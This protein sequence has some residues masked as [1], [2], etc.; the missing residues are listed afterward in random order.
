MFGHA[1]YD[2][3]EQVHFAHDEASGLTAIVAI[4]STALGP[5]FGGCRMWPYE[6]EDRALADA[7]RLLRGMTYKAAI[8]ELPYGGGKSVII[9]DPK[10]QKTDR[11]LH[12]MG[13]VVDGFG[14]AYIIADDVGIGLADLAVMRHE[15]P[16]TAAASAAAQAPL[17][18]TGYGVLMAIEAATS[19]VL[20]RADLAGLRVAV[21]G[22]GAVGLALCRLLHERGARLIVADIDDARV[23]DA[24]ASFAAEAVPAD[25]IYDVEADIFAPCALGAVLNEETVQR[26][27]VALVC[28]GA[29]NQLRYPHHDIELA[30]RG[31]VFVPDY[32]ANAGGVIDYYQEN[33]DDRPEAILR[34]VERIRD[35]TADLLARAK[36]S[37]DTPRTVAEKI[38]A[39]RLAAAV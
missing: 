6:D 2:G 8:C 20:G 14:G 32:L 33:I 38:V 13:R 7:L 31:I 35:I 18:V 12:A 3:H 25:A 23:R 11:L 26:L 4:H 21:Q 30:K 1:D 15:T 27:R 24:Q 39:Q 16:H 34:A 5:A 9:G 28:G 10:T 19:G 29:N 36:Q 22:L 17:G 37:G